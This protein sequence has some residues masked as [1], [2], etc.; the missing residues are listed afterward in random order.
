MGT[1][2]IPA[3]ATGGESSAMVGMRYHVTPSLFFALGVSYDKNH[4][5][6][7]RPGITYRFGTR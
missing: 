6:L 3:E 1:P 7:I 5:L 2:G 4:A